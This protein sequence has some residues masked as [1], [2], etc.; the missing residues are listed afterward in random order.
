MTGSRAWRFLSVVALAALLQ[1]CATA[2]QTATGGPEAERRYGERL[3]RLQA[4]DHWA[5]HGRLAVRDGEEGGSGTLRWHAEPAGARL[6]FH[7]ALGRGA[8]RLQVSP[9]EAVLTLADGAEYR[10]ASVERLVAE[11]IGWAVPVAELS[12]WIR[13]LAAPGERARRSLGETGVLLDLQQAGWSVAFDRYRRFGDEL[14]PGLVV[15]R[16]GERL[17]KFAVRDWTLSAGNAVDG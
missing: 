7:G 12:W 11:Q 15:A 9:G 8:W 10:A 2:P 5:V 4:A 3:A 17:V 13:G 14:M 6:D 16:R 1:A